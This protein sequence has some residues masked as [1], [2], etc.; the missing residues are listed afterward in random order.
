MNGISPEG[1]TDPKITSA[2]A[3]PPIG[4]G[5]YASR[6]EV[7]TSAIPLRSLGRPEIMTNTIGVVE[8]EASALTY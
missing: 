1:E 7:E 8:D 4:P 5:R 2:I 3:C 6:T